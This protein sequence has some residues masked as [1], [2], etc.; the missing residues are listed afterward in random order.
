M[1]TAIAI[2]RNIPDNVN[3]NDFNVYVASCFLKPEIL[4][5][6][7][8]EKKYM[9]EITTIEIIEQLKFLNVSY[10][11]GRNSIIHEILGEQNEN[12]NSDY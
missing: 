2:I 7:R 11:L 5:G 10:E 12:F 1:K 4:S 6:M 3:L 8:I 9:P